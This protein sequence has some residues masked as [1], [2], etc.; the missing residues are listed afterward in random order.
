[1][2]YHTV[3]EMPTRV[4]LISALTFCLAR[5][6]PSI[7]NP[8][9][10][11]PLLLPTTRF[12]SPLCRHLPTQALQALPIP[13]PSLAPTPTVLSSLK[14]S[15]S[16]NSSIPHLAPPNIPLHT[17]TIPL[18]HVHHPLTTAPEP[19]QSMQL[20]SPLPSPLVFYYLL[21]TKFRMWQ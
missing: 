19:P 9:V 11:N 12:N 18:L 6:L 14:P 7:F 3:S 2:P 4:F 5:L 8:C 16:L 15:L 17:L 21:S 1:M 13:S 10:P 20:S